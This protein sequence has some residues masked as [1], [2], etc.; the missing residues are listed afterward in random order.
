MVTQHT[1]FVLGAFTS[2]RELWVVLEGEGKPEYGPWKTSDGR[3]VIDEIAVGRI[4]ELP[5]PVDFR[6]DTASTGKKR[7]DI[8]WLGGH[9]L[10]L[11][12]RRF[13]EA[14]EE[15]G[16]TGWLTYPVELRDSG[17]RS[18][19]PIEGYVGFVPDLT[20]NAPVRSYNVGTP[21]FAIRVRG[22]ILDGLKSRGVVRF[23]AELAEET[24]V[25]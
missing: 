25:E 9:P 23:S 7:G 19:E 5:F 20:G 18:G 10:L 21:N 15:M 24:L 2:S 22:D 12:S 11:V 1:W 16:V 8:L 4:A 14:L 6:R 3:D 13:V 17:R